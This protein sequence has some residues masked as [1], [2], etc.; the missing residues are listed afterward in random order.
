MLKNVWCQILIDDVLHVDMWIGLI[1]WLEKIQTDNQ[2]K[3]AF[4]KW[5]YKQKKAKLRMPLA[6]SNLYFEFIEQPVSKAQNF[7]R[8]LKAKSTPKGRIKLLF[9]Y[10]LQLVR[11]FQYGSKVFPFLRSPHFDV[12]LWTILHKTI[13]ISRKGPTLTG[14]RLGEQLVILIKVAN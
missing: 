12:E 6:N 2:R 14:L 8:G 3:E 9:P 10:K 4:K 13:I 11:I 1:G 7:L 5:A